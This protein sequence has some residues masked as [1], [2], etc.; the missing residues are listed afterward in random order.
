HRTARPRDV[1]MRTARIDAAL[2]RFETQARA[3][4]I[5]VV[6]GEWSDW[7]SHGH[8][9]TAREVAVYREARSFARAAQTAHA[10]ARLRGP[11]DPVRFEVMGYRRGPVRLRDHAE[12][13]CDLDRVD[14]RLLL[15]G[16]HT[17]GSWETYSKPFSTFSHSHWNAKAGFAYEAYD[18]ARDLAIEG[19]FRLVGSGDRTSREVAGE[20]VV[21]NP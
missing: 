20:L 9:S 8:G 21:V 11:G 15:F 10:L 13:A 14:E 18:V 5:P 17:W 16:G 12:L 3:A 7:W 1:R 6:A 19:W 2:D 4:E